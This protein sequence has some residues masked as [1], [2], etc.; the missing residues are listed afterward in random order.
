M[1][2]QRTL[3]KASSSIRTIPLLGGVET[4]PCDIIFLL[5]A[6]QAEKSVTNYRDSSSVQRDQSYPNAIIHKWSAKVYATCHKRESCD[7]EVSD[8]VDPK[9]IDGK[10]EKRIG[11]TT[12]AN[13]ENDGARYHEV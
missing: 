6:Q 7:L 4:S 9:P 5:N 10:L 1:S 13:L 8:E 11:L 3:N 2:I 12:V